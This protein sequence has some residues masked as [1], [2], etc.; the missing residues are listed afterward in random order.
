MRDTD[1][2]THASHRLTLG[3]VEKLIVTVLIAAVVGVPAYLWRKQEAQQERQQEVLQAVDTR[4]Q[5]MAQQMTALSAQMA[6]VPAMR[7]QMAELKVQVA[8]NTQAIAELRAMK[9]LK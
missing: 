7:I 2:D 8:A 5:V 4:T 3:P 1:P 6:D 9:G